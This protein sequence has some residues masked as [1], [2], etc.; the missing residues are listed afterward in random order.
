MDNDELVQDL[1]DRTEEW[2]TQRGI[3][4]SDGAL[5]FDVFLDR[6]NYDLHMEVDY[7]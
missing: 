4:N 2:N 3:S 1:I 7:E 5:I 6:E